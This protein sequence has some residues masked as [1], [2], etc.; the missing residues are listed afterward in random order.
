MTDEVEVNESNIHEHLTNLLS[1]KEPQTEV[2]PK[3]PSTEVKQTEEPKPPVEGAEEPIEASGEEPQDDKTPS[4]E[5]KEGADVEDSQL[6][7]SSL[8]QA[9]G[10]D[11]TILDL[12]EE[13]EPIFKVKI[14][15][16][17]QYAKAKDLIESYQ[18]K[19]HLNKNN[20]E[21]V[22]M[23]NRLSAEIESKKQESDAKISQIDNALTLLNQQL[24][25][26]FQGINWAELERSNPAAYNTLRLK[27]SDKQAHL[28][29]ITEISQ[30]DRYQKIQQQIESNRKALHDKVPEW[31]DDEA[32]TKAY[33]EIR[34]GAK[35]YGF[36]PSETDS[37]VDHRFLIVLRDALAYQKL[38]KSRPEQLKKLKSVPK[39]V[40]PG[41]VQPA[42]SKETAL[43]KLRERVG[44]DMPMSD[45]L[46]QSGIANVRGH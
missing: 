38:Q 30:M 28:R 45:F 2:K 6:T 3:E 36:D 43:Q 5:P 44:K 10:V 37:M 34:N 1:T 19:G 22:E 15:G 20:M 40:K 8:A 23:R 14:D 13:G 17:E 39:F 24:N 31:K 42:V 11:E 21:V 18:L 16:V 9:I 25:S 46:K 33:S 35:E 41:A 26:E 32:Y 7:V 29:K 4:E 12:N 27:Y